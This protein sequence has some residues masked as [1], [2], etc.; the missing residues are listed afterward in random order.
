MALETEKKIT[1][2]EE[3]LKRIEE[4]YSLEMSCHENG[5]M[6]DQQG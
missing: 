2:I 4:S 5:P 1:Q 3:R 6:C